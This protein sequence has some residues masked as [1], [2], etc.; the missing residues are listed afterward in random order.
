[1]TFSLA[2]GP[3][4]RTSSP[5]DNTNKF[6]HCSPQEGTPTQM[7]F[8]AIAKM[9]KAKLVA[10]SYYYVRKAF[11]FEVV[12][13]TPPTCFMT[14]QRRRC[15]N[16]PVA[17]FKLVFLSLPLPVLTTNLNMTPHGIGLQFCKS[18]SE[19][20]FL[21]YDIVTTLLLHCDCHIHHFFATQPESKQLFAVQDTNTYN[22][23]TSLGIVCR[24]QWTCMHNRNSDI[25]R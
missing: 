2:Y 12:L 24:K 16:L 22:C 17:F 21:L 11:T 13:E 18:M 19:P 4:I 6:L 8:A 1:M 5:I 20:Y 14:S 10:H 9:P 25:R 23:L 3:V 7:E 15:L